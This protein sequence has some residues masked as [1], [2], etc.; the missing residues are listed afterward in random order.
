MVNIPRDSGAF[1]PGLGPYTEFMN[2]KDSPGRSS[3]NQ[4]KSSEIKR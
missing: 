3:I 2:R 4:A 1:I